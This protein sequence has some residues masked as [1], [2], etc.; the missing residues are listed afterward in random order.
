MLSALTDP[1]CSPHVLVGVLPSPIHQAQF[2]VR[3]TSSCLGQDLAAVDAC[4][5]PHR[6]PEGQS[7]IRLVPCRCQRSDSLLLIEARPCRRLRGDESRC[8]PLSAMS[9]RRLK[10][11]KHALL[12]L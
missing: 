7:T 1:A 4:L 11:Q 6:R 9:L 2:L 3:L 12:K 8:K 10:G 5:T